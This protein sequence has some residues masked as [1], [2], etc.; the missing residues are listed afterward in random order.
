MNSSMILRITSGLLE[1]KVF[2]VEENAV[3]GRS[4]GNILLEDP[5]ISNPHAQIYKSDNQYILKNLSSKRGIRYRDKTVSFIILQ[6]GVVFQLGS[7]TFQVDENV[8]LS[9]VTGTSQEQN[10]SLSQV[11]G[12]SQEQSVSSLSVPNEQIDTDGEDIKIEFLK[13]LESSVRILKDE[14][15]SLNFLKNPIQ[16]Q[17]EQG[18]QKNTVWN[19]CYLPRKIGS[20]DADLPLIDPQA[21]EIS[22]ELFLEKEKV[23]FFTYHKDIVLLNYQHTQKTPLKDGDLI[24]IGAVYIR[25]S[26]N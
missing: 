21:P 16:L 13:Q 20:I 8:P 9:Q 6:P 19:L 3:L 22:F 10:V 5:K 24:I 25:V 4:K 15:R 2:P 11:T 1:G 26:M 14:S 12:T 7:T 23:M 17:F 18:A